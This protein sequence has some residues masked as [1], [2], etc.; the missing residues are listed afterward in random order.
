MKDKL[1]ALAVV[2]GRLIKPQGVRQDVEEPRRREQG[3][4]ALQIPIGPSPS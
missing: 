1:V 3:R 4:R 2:Q